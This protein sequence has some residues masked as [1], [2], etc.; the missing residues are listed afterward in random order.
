MSE[1]PPTSAGLQSWW[2]VIPRADKTLKFCLVTASLQVVQVKQ[3]HGGSCQSLTWCSSWFHLFICSYLLPSR[4]QFERTQTYSLLFL[5]QHLKFTPCSTGILHQVWLIPFF[6]TLL[7]Y[8]TPSLVSHLSASSPNPPHNAHT[9]PL[10]PHFSLCILFPSHLFSFPVFCLYFTF[11]HEKE[12]TFLS[13]C[14]YVWER[15]NVS[16]HIVLPVCTVNM[17]SAVS[18]LVSVCFCRPGICMRVVLQSAVCA[19][20]V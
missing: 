11:C 20:C 14:V 1:L 18:V 2:S 3:T 8:I 13:D 16:A 12:Q 7:V 5:F 15:Q 6:F 19:T 17:S 10:T 4:C 9:L